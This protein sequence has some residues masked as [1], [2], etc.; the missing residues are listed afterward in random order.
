MPQSA[1]AVWCLQI[2]PFSSSVHE[3]MPMVRSTPYTC[4]ASD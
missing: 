3:H 1:H 2:A 4:V